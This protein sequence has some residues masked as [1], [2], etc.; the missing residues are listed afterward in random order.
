MKGFLYTIEQYF[1]ARDA[2]GGIEV[3]AETFHIQIS[4]SSYNARNNASSFSEAKS[5]L[6]SYLHPR[7]V[8]HKH[9]C[10]QHMSCRVTPESDAIHL[11]GLMKVNHLQ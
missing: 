1:R 6:F 11:Q 7:N 10:T 8:N 9:C 4:E 3:D 5:L 2:L